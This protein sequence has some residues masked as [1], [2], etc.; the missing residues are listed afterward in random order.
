MIKKSSSLF[1]FAIFAYLIFCAIQLGVTWDT[2]FYYELG[3]DRLDYL[4]SFGR[5]DSFL[6]VPHSKYLPGAYSTISAFFVQ[7]FPKKYLVESLYFINL[8][9]SFLCLVGIYKISKELFNKEIA[10]ITFII[11]F[12]NPIFFGH[13]AVNQN[14]NILTFAN[15][16][17]FYYLLRY[18]KKQNENSK[19]NKYVILS[20]LLLGL[21]LGVRTSF[22]V[23]LIPLFIFFVLDYFFSKS[24]FK[25][26]FSIRSF[27]FDSIKVVFISYLFM[28]LFWP[29]THGNILIM[30]FILAIE[31]LSFGFGVPF[32]M[33]NSEIF[34][35]NEF[36]KNYIFINLFYKL[37][38]FV[39]LSYLIFFILLIKLLKYF[40]GQFNSFNNKI[41]LIFIII[42]FPNILLIFSPYSPYDG[43]RFFLYLI[44]YI[45]I[46]PAILIFYFLKNL[47]KNY[48][49]L[50]SVIYFL[51]VIFHVANFFYLTPFHY[52]YLNLMAGKTENHHKKF[53]NDY[54]GISTKKLINQIDKSDKVKKNLVVKLATCG[55]E[56]KAQEMYLN[57]IKNFKF[58]IVSNNE[59]YD[60]IIM[61][62]RIIFNQPKNSK[63]IQTCFEKFVGKS[64]TE[65]KVRNLV[66]SKIVQKVP[67]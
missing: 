1:L 53:E 27:S 37:P 41:F 6:R 61:N 32:V 51:L 12:F 57:K 34:L 50:I 8:S 16:W 2:F 29:H 44:P 25:K 26:G 59:D 11:C 10:I 22:L 45:S 24:L 42:L 5:D 52:V 62:N 20:G 31:G 64:V 55:I 63:K 49:K 39:I 13:M 54:W 17:F 56:E 36:P 66:I 30:P 9:F 14:D 47:K 7:F 48:I 18:F 60:F 19:R 21:G 3:K 23:T 33:L 43:L 46:I 67:N 28:V 35:T 58:K 65:I 38:E 4:L 40:N 15:I